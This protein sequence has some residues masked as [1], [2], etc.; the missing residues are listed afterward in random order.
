M[1][2]AVLPQPRS[3]WASGNAVTRPDVSV[4][5]APLTAT[6]SLPYAK[7]Q[8]DVRVP[9]EPAMLTCAGPLKLCAQALGRALALPSACFNV[10]GSAALTVIVV[11]VPVSGLVKVPAPESRCSFIPSENATLPR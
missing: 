8:S 5:D 6:E 3:T 10:S 7:R 9:P 4:Y 1:V 11:V 2:L